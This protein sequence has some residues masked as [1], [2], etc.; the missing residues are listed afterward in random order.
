VSDGTVVWTCVS[1]L[2]LE[3]KPTVAAPGS[4]VAAPRSRDDPDSNSSCCDQLVVDK[5]GT[6]MSSPHVAGLVALMLEK[7]R[8]LTFEA[9]RGHLQR[10]TRIDGI[11]AGE[12]PQIFD[13][14]LNIR[15]GQIWGSGK[16]D[17]AA[18]LA[19]IVPLGG[20]GGGPFPFI[21]LNEA[22]LG[23]TP[24]T[25]FSRLGDWNRRY[26]PR[27]GL[28]L[29]AALLSEH[30]DEVL[31]LINHNRRVGTVWRREGG[32]VLARHL[33]F[34][35]GAQ[36]SLLPAAL[37]GCDVRTL[38]RRFLP[39]LE[40]FGG[41]KLRRDVRCYAAFADSWPGASVQLLDERALALKGTP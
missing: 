31:R 1:A 2:V 33:L 26:G 37:E 39:I 9:L 36:T 7:N 30:F 17:A 29:M 21:S 23:Y 35:H 13:T 3:L 8:T 40:R 24:H 34:H 25:V 18:A 4:G 38:I 6:S 10:T 32:P 16:V 11:P 14:L 27:P 15:A 22:E 12:V 19:D 41:A 28:M 5:S 20:G